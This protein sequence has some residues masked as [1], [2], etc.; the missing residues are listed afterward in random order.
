[1]NITKKFGKKA[2]AF[3]LAVAMLVGVLMVNHATTIRFVDV[4][5]GQWYSEP[6]NRLAEAG[7]VS[8]VGQNK[9]EPGR[10][11]ANAEMVKM[12]VNAFFRSEYEAYEAA[13]SDAMWAHFGTKTYWFSFMCYYARETGLLDGVN[14]DIDDYGSCYTYMSRYDMAMVLYNAAAKKGVTVSADDKAVAKA[15]LMSIGHY[16]F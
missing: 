14:V 12:L 4:P 10:S 5:D 3:V 13:N 8:G 16:Y 15:E 7:V 1:M 2:I 11:V 9:F 6:I